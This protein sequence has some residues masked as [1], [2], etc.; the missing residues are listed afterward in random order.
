MLSSHIIF[1][2]KPPQLNFIWVWKGAECACFGDNKCKLRLLIR[3][4]ITSVSQTLERGSEKP[5]VGSPSLEDSDSVV[6]GLDLTRFCLDCALAKKSWTRGSLRS[7]PA[8]SSVTLWHYLILIWLQAPVNLQA[9][10][11]SAKPYCSQSCGT[12]SSGMGYSSQESN[13]S[14][15][16]HGKERIM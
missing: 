9:T 4:R 10:P 6:Q 5:P 14:A 3:K 8:C 7:L 13:C 16:G 15:W 2:G 12:G 11:R 1:Q